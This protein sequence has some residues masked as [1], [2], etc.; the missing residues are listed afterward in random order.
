MILNG[1]SKQEQL[2]KRILM[3]V[4]FQLPIGIPLIPTNSQV[5]KNV[6]VLHHLLIDVI[7]LQLKPCPCI[8]EV[9]QLVLL[10][11]AKPKLLKILVEHW[12]FSSWLQIVL[13]NIDIVIWPKFSKVQYRVVFGDAL[14]NSIVLIQKSY[15]SQQ[16]K[17]NQLQLQENNT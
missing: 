15:L 2:G 8:T 16:C 5:L 14:M 9:L 7:L 11:L 1:K 10:G 3:N 4:S 17:Q 6:Y 12:V 13:I